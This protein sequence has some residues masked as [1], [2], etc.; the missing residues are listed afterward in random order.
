MKDF[1]FRFLGSLVLHSTDVNKH[2][3]L[4]LS[5]YDFVGKG[6]NFIK[7]GGEVL[8]FSLENVC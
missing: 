5:D 1:S 7:K 3:F 4:T 2:H 6:N 8:M